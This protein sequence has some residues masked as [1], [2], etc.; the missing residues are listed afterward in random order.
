M[1]EFDPMP[2]HDDEEQ[3]DSALGF[4]D[5]DDL[6]NDEFMGGIDDSTQNGDNIDEMDLKKMKIHPILNLKEE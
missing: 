4:E 3:L 1:G 6:N 2:T 5:A